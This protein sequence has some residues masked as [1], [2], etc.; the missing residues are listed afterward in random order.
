MLSFRGYLSQEI[1]V[2]QPNVFD[3]MMVNASTENGLL[4]EKAPKK[5]RKILNTNLCHKDP[6]TW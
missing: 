3:Y 6:L 1:L 5:L 2:T 4:R